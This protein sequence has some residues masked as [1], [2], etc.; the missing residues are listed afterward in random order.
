MSNDSSEAHLKNLID[1]T[2]SIADFFGNVELKK[3][4]ASLKLD[5]EE[6][7]RFEKVKRIV[8]QTLDPG[9]YAMIQIFKVF[10]DE[11][12]H[13]WQDIKK[14]AD[15]SKVT[16]NKKL[17]EL[18]RGGVLKR[19]VIAS[20]PPRTQYELNEK[21]LGPNVYKVLINLGK[22]LYLSEEA[23]KKMLGFYIAVDHLAQ[24]DKTE[25]I[26]PNATEKI[27]KTFLEENLRS[28]SSDV[29]NPLWK[30]DKSWHSLMATHTTYTL[31]LWYWT[32]VEVTTL[33]PKIKN[34]A[35]SLLTIASEELMKTPAKIETH[36][37]QTLNK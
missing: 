37:N 19:Y 24:A 12:Q 2:D 5:V 20:F 23:V 7:E 26:D 21:T 35:E 16:L 13:G 33:N 18:T 17:K 28:L 6:R 30:L 15:V 31:M 3:L 25:Q 10:K 4:A 14:A 36:S 11:R 22:T 34:L 27:I 1:I 8:R 29:H 9:S 32:I